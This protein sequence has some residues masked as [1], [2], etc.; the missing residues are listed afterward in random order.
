MAHPNTK[1]TIVHAAPLPI[2]DLFP[3]HF[4]K[5]VIASLKEFGIDIVLGEKVDLSTIDRKGPV[6]LPS[7]KVLDADLVV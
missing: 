1:I 5:R 6:Q 7:G 2:S 3:E 4:R